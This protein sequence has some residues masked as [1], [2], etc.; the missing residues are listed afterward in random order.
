MCYWGGLI[1]FEC[2]FPPCISLKA[3]NFVLFSTILFIW[4]WSFNTHPI[5]H[6]QSTQIDSR[7]RGSKSWQDGWLAECFELFN[8]AVDLSV[9]FALTR[10]FTP[11]YSKEQWPRCKISE[12]T[13]FTH[14]FSSIKDKYVENTL[15]VLDWERGSFSLFYLSVFLFLAAFPLTI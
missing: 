5:V 10:L 12:K 14:N 7:V 13:Y 6:S 1:I 9:S 3:K 4:F 2:F 15:I 8:G 11:L